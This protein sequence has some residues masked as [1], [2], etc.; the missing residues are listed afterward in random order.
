M[1]KTKTI[2][3]VDIEYVAHRLAQE[4]LEWNEPIPDFRTRYPFVLERC[5]ATVFQTYSYKAL[6]PGLLR[7]SATLFY[8]MIK[9][10]PFQ[11][12]NKR[13][14]M[15]ATLYFLYKNKKWLR[16]DNQELYNFSKWVA[17]SNPKLKEETVAAIE[18]F[19]KG[20][21]VDRP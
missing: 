15:T 21:L 12:G 3:V 8:L 20:Y 1:A 16:V 7:K 17:E 11:N 5:V 13:I 18:K 14:A 4:T 10:H 2:S 9:N 6:Y 19:F